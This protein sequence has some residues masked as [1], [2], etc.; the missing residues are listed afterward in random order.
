M[1]TDYHALLKEGHFYHIYNRTNGHDLLFAER[2]NY[3]FFLEK[4]KLYLGNYTDTYAYCLMGNHFH[5]I[6]RVK[7]VD[8]AF[9]E[10]VDKEQ[11]VAARKFLANDS[12]VNNF[13]EDQFKRFFNS[14]AASFNKYHTR[15]GSLFQKRFKRVL[16]SDK[17]VLLDKICY[18]HHNPIHHNFS[19]YYEGWHF[20]SFNAYLTQHKTSVQRVGGLSLFEGLPAF[21]LYHEQYKN[22][23]FGFLG[24]GIE[25]ES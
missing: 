24:D 11:T 12:T 22:N 6:I 25:S 10:A 16:I 2:K 8:S 23:R 17:Q 20:S 14:Y 19:D 9:K 7:S 3:N 5:F 1:R 4:W 18:V 21:L 15:H 13:L